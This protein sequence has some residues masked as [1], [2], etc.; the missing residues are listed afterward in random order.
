MWPQLR[1]IGQH[2][3]QWLNLHLRLLSLPASA[4]PV[5][6]RQIL[7]S[8]VCSLQD[9]LSCFTFLRLAAALCCLCCLF[10]ANSQ[11]TALCTFFRPAGAKCRTEHNCRPRLLLFPVSFPDHSLQSFAFFRCR[12]PC[13]LSACGLNSAAWLCSAILRQKGPALFC[14]NCKFL[15]KQSMTMGINLI[16]TANFSVKNP[17]IKS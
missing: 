12:M 13:A 4:V 17:V 7:Q 10:A 3:K 9:L 15:H 11:R 2:L 16:I 14:K 1:I 6:L 8:A 5:V